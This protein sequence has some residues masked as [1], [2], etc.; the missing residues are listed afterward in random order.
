MRELT[1]E[2]VEARREAGRKG[3]KA[4]FEK[5]GRE[6]M[7]EIGSKGYWATGAKLG[8]EATNRKIFGRHLTGKQCKKL[9]KGLAGDGY[10][11]RQLLLGEVSDE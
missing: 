7:A 4:L 11:Q 9:K 8:W 5:Y 2:E 3:G 1:P 10:N 6:Y